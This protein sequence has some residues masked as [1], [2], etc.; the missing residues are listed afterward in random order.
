APDW[1]RSASNITL[2]A[3]GSAIYTTT[4]DVGTYALFRVDIASGKATKIVGGGSVGG[5][6]LAGDTLA[7]TFE[8]L[9]SPAQA[10]VAR[11]DGSQARQVTN[12]NAAV[13]A[14]IEFGAYEQ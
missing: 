9:D 5:Y 4:N 13:L 11:A 14:G 2:S 8:D 3:D 10:F 7:Y 1:D 6:D 12:N